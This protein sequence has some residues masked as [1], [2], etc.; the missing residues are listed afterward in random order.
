MTSREAEALRLE[1]E[2]RDPYYDQLSPRSP[3]AQRRRRPQAENPQTHPS[4]P[5]LIEADGLDG[6]QPGA[7]QSNGQQAWGWSV[8][9]IFN[10]T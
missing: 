5:S 2:A 7:Q 8:S 1:N 4:S 6:Q 9:S 3:R 10:I